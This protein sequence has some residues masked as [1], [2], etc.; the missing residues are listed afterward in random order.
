MSGIAFGFELA[1]YGAIGACVGLGPGGIA[2]YAASRAIRN[3]SRDSV[4]IEH[5][6]PSAGNNTDQ[7]VH[8]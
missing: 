8:T 2:L 4:K 3:I 5:K 7:F 1:K 6:P